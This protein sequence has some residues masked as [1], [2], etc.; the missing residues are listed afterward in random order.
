MSILKRA[1]PV[2]SWMT[3]SICVLAA[4]LCFVAFGAAETMADREFSARIGEINNSNR[5]LALT[6]KE[7]AQRTFSEADFILRD[8]KADIEEDGQLDRYRDQLLRDVI[9][10]GTISQIA[11]TDEVGNVVYTT[12]KVEGIIN[13]SD[14][15]HFRFHKDYKTDDLFI[16][17]PVL[18]RTSQT[19][20]YFMTRR[21]NDK[22]G[23]F[24]GVVVVGVKRDYFDQMFLRLNLGLGYVISLGKTNGQLL[25]QAP[26]DPSPEATVNFQRYPALNLIRQ[27]VREGVYESD[28]ADRGIPSFEAFNTI[29]DYSL[30][31]SV[32]VAKEAALAQVY[33]HRRV[34]RGIAAIFSLAVFAAFYGLWRQIRKERQAVKALDEHNFFLSSLHEISLGMMNRLD[35]NE[36]LTDIATRAAELTGAEH[37]SVFVIDDEKQCA[38]R[39]VGIGLFAQNVGSS[40][41]LADGLLGEAYRQNRTVVVEDYSSWNQRRADSYLA[42]VHTN[43]HVPLKAGG[44]MIGSLGVAFTDKN[45]HFTEGDVALMEQFASL[46]AVAL[47]NASLYTS[48]AESDKKLQESFQ[49][50]TSA[51]EELYATEEELR[52]QYDQALEMNEQIVRQ[53]T[54]LSTLH[55]TTLGL[56]NHLELNEV[57]RT[58]V[59]RAAKLAGTDSAF[60]MLLHREK[61]YFVRE[62]AIGLYEGDIGGK[63]K[64][65]QGLVGEV[66]RLGRTVVIPDY[67]TWDKRVP[68]P[69]FD[70]VHAN[71]HVPLKDGN[72]VIGTLGMASTDPDK[73][74]FSDE[75]ISLV[76]QFAQLASIAYI[77]AQLHSSLVGS[78]KQLQ[79]K[80]EELTAAHEEVLASEEELKEQ[81]HELF[82]REE[83]IR[84]QN[85]VL[86]TLHETTLGLVSR[87]ELNDVLQLIVSGA[88]SLVGT[89]HG[90]INLFDEARGVYIRKIGLG[91]YEKDV[92][93]EIKKTEGM[94]GQVGRTGE[95]VV[96]DDYRSWEYRL[97]DAFFD[98]VHAQAQ[99]PLRAGNKVVG[100]FGL[101]FLEPDRKFADRE[102]TLLS[103]FAEM[104]SIALDNAMLL[105]SYKSEIAERAQAEKLQKALY[106]ISETVSSSDNLEELY[107]SVHSIV[108]ELIPAK[109]FFI[110]IHDEAT[111]TLHYPYRV[112]EQDG[113]PGSRKF[114]KGMPEYIIRTGKPALIN[115]EL[116]AKLEAQGEV[117]TVGTPGLDWLGVPLKT[118][119]NKVFGVMGVQT[120]SERVRYTQK[121]QDILIFVSNQVAMAIERKQAEATSKYLGLHDALTGLYN[122][123]Y[124]TEEMQRHQGDRYL[125]NT[126]VMCDLDGLKLVND[127][128]GHAAG[129]KLLAATAKIIRKVI[130][131]GDVAARIG[132]DEF[133]ILLPR[134]NEKIAVSL[135][136]RLKS[137]IERYNH[138]TPGVPLSVSFGYAV[139]RTLDISIEDLLKEADN[140]MYR[141]KLHHSRS[142]RSAIVQTVMKLLEERDFVTEEHAERLQ[143]LTAKL[144]QRLNLTESRVA[145]IRLLAKFH[146]VGKIGI[147]DHILLK[148]G[149]LTK[150]EWAEMKR[151]CE[152]GFRIAQ[153]SPDLVPISDWILK[154]HEWWNGQGYPFGLQ[155]KEIPLECRILAIADCYDAMTSDRPYRKAVSHEAALAEIAR[156]AGTQFDPE[157]AKTFIAI[158]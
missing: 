120:F 23:D 67:S 53:N 70:S 58:I 89:T 110:T 109:N 82:A 114:V 104:A 32:A 105:D 147:P 88:A 33:S 57:L 126:V 101:V 50:L 91:Y 121:D 148:E 5:S 7:N 119:S 132:G 106:L 73:K 79:K 37:A 36:V 22:N 134:A 63:V 157:L 29:P 93:R 151:H 40:V 9:S 38:V 137:Q 139:R 14:R 138:K 99:V 19:Y 118:A 133:A 136:E 46:A 3:V 127:T 15:E 149:P 154:H 80:N 25:A 10:K 76:E 68:N 102:V 128:F 112:D 131:Q 141:E 94:S 95:I 87:Q 85:V 27:G 12:A 71:M 84:R 107:Q 116:R 47:V 158:M 108:G 16:S 64:I 8:V 31:V 65:G 1:E 143:E 4:A 124:F 39:K 48:L 54:V 115:P 55:E 11:V 77:N 146:D 35:V 135:S 26:V 66:Y 92:G 142:A 98:A 52:A 62:I 103:R 140:N 96:T 59:T 44:K 13:V 156:C 86:T 153:S 130:R 152:I 75:T 83:E 34:Y 43:A 21:L 69:L 17:P 45:L 97:P 2:F 51:H 28:G 125:P 113:N 49:D 122:R 117:K 30:F 155:G 18:S 74:H 111:G 78:E 61:G 90:Y 145:E 100:S 72:E 150:Q 81:L 6:L 60:M 24:A 144:T 129:D 42:Q 56:M 123:A 41:N 20:A